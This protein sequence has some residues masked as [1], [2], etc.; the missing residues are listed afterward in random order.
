MSSIKAAAT[1]PIS[2]ALWILGLGTFAIGTDAFIVAGVLTEIAH[3][4]KTSIAAA[5]QIITLFAISYAIF[6]PVSAWLSSHWTRRRTVLLAIFIF[7]FSNLLSS[8]A[9]SYAILAMSRIIAAAAAATYT[10]QAIAS[11]SDLV[12]ADRKGQA[13]AIVY[14]G[15]TLAIALGVP[16]GTLIG[17][18]I[19]WRATFLIVV[20]L[21][22]VT[23]VSLAC[24]LPALPIPP[25]HS[26]KERLLVLTNRHILIIFLITFLTV[27]S[28]HTV[29]SYISVI[30]DATRWGN[31]RILPIGLICFGIGAV[32]GNFASGYATDR[33]SARTTLLLAVCLQTTALL[34]VSFVYSSA[35][36]TCSVLFLWGTA[37]WMYLVPIQHR[38]LAISG[39]G[40]QL[41]ISL[42]SSVLYLGIAAGAVLGGSLVALHF[43]RE[44]GIAGFIIGLIS[45]VVIP[46]GYTTPTRA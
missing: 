36:A 26:L 4:L 7:T 18:N 46:F 3:E 16:F 38:L 35:I 43:T 6:A 32:L 13:L 22:A 2:P 17:Q 37:G 40:S 12:P 45:L 8:L 9:P 19:G 1:T 23:F 24:L 44:L 14:G 39:T 15:M 27:L 29:Y 31:I 25:R 5:G 11:V 10:P 33:L 34:L 20:A 41:T 30:F 28:E 21:G 42:N